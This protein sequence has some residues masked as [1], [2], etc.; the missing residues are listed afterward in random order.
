MLL[1]EYI[2]IV[3]KIKQIIEDVTGK[4]IY[5][6]PDGLYNGAPVIDRKLKGT[7]FDNIFIHKDIT[8]IISEL[9]TLKIN[10]KISLKERLEIL[11]K[12]RLDYRNNYYVLHNVVLRDMYTIDDINELW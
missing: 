8:E 7:H 12:M 3:K 9:G 2:L 6:K 1:K 4:K 5:T 11:K 10:F